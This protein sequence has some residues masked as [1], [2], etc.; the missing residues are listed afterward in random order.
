[1][2]TGQAALPSSIDE[3]I[4]GFSPD[5]QQ[6]LEQIRNAIR[7]IAPD[8][9]ETIK[10]RMPTF[11][12]HE[13]LVHFAAYTKHVGFYPTPSGIS[14]FKDELSPYNSAKGSVQFPI[15]EPIPLTL[16]KNIV[17]FRVK[18]VRAK[19]AAKKGK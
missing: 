2:R 16:I 14:K 9:E 5:I 18:E 10:Y 19:S 15:D 1:M 17:R 3:Y 7:A 8:A 11:V 13:N 4:A 12:L 6:V